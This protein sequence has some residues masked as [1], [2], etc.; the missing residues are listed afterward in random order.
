MK[1]FRKAVASMLLC[2]MLLYTMPVMAYV[3]DEDVYTKMDSTGKPYKVIVTTTEK[4]EQGNDQNVEN[5][6]DKELPFDCKISYKLDGKA[7]HVLSTFKSLTQ[8]S[9]H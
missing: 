6:T 1:M 2:S 7:R 5:E 9:T 4:D 8:V 3:N